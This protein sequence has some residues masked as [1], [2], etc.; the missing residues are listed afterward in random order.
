M[1]RRVLVS[2]KRVVQPDWVY[3]SPLVGLLLNQLQKR[4]KKTVAEKVLYE[5]FDIIRRWT[6]EDP[7]NVFE[8]AVRYARPAFGVW[9]TK[10]GRSRWYFPFRYRAYRGISLCLRWIVTA[11]R[12]RSGHRMSRKLAR[13]II[14]TAQNNSSSIRKRRALYSLVKEHYFRKPR[15]PG[16]P[17]K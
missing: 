1:P 9:C 14:A 2:R 15:K 16:K 3:R 4:G 10:R 5:S 13:E 12:D 8:Q 17:N 7:L 11:A 6:G